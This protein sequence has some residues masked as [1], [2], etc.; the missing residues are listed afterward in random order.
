VADVRGS[1]GRILL[2]LA[3]ALG[4]A[5]ALLAQTAE[6]AVLI[7]LFAKAK[8]QFRGAGYDSSLA[9][10]QKLDDA[11]RAPGLET[12]RERLAPGLAFYRG[13][14]LAALGKKSEAK[15]QFEIY[16]AATHVSRL[17]PSMYPKAVLDAFEEA[18]S[19]S[20]RS[21]PGANPG[22]GDAHPGLV[23]AYAKFGTSAAPPLAIDA[24]WGE[25]A[26]R[27]LMTPSER[28]Q[29]R[30][31]AD[32]ASRAEFV[33]AFWQRRDPTPETPENEYRIEVERR[34]AFADA[35]FARGEKRGSETDRGLVFVVMGPPST[36]SDT[37]LRIE[38]DPIQAA[39]SAPR[40][41]V[42]STGGRGSV[43]TVTPQ[44]MSADKI[45]GRRETWH[46]RRDRLPAAVPYQKIDFEFLTKEGYGLEVLQRE[47]NVLTALDLA[48]RPSAAAAGG[49]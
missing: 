16:I 18:K 14:N 29:W 32:D 12:A 6:E 5:V 46:Y 21:D 43:M 20:A 24:S 27:F 22:P 44:P 48:A 37:L 33:A 38:D 34:I 17:D 15:P 26:I 11:S 41:V 49:R 28:E 47:P 8:A 42:Q 25:G 10:L 19:E 1:W 2:A 4:A 3:L 40:T 30:L 31:A 35:R 9:T 39:R 7:E 36:V 23:D 13:A 45:Q